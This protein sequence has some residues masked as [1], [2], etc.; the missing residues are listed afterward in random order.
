MK[1]DQPSI[2][3]VDDQVSDL[4]ILG[5]ALD[6]L[7]EVHIATDGKRALELAYQCRPDVIVLDVEMPL[8]DGYSVCEQVKADPRLAHAAVIFVTSHRQ[9]E[10]ELRGL[11]LGGA[12]FLHKP[13][14]PPVA[15]ARVEA[16]IKHGQ[17]VRQ[18]AYYDPLTRLPNRT[19][20]LNRVEQALKNGR[21]PETL[22]GLL[23]IDLDN[24]KALNDSEGHA[25]GDALLQEIARRLAQC[26]SASDTA[27]RAGGQRF[28]LLTLGLDTEALGHRAERVLAAIAQPIV[29]AGV[30]YDLVGHIGISVY[31]QDGEDVETLHQHADAALYQA[32]QS[33]RGHYR[34]F[35]ASINASVRARHQMERDLRSALDEGQL[36]VFYQAKVHVGLRQV[37]GVEALVR[38]PQPDGSM[39]PPDRFIPLAEACGLIVPLGEFVLFSACDALRQWHEEGHDISVSVNISPLQFHDPGFGAMI[40]QAVARSG[41]VPG[42]LELEI[43][44][45]VLASDVD[46]TCRLLGDIRALGVGISIDDFGTGYS[47][48]AYLKRYPLDVLKIDQSFV[49]EMLLQERDTAIVETI[50]RLGHALQ[51]QLVAEG[52]ETTEQSAALQRLGCEIM[53]GYLYCRPMPRARM[54]EYL[55]A[56]PRLLQGL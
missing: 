56:A 11:T 40:R 26:C 41:G 37:V 1:L 50:I 33:G 13:I 20:L 38:W 30:R 8:M 5:Q 42:G 45:G 3:I 44:E 19:L 22:V 27:S 55:R 36:R 29:I 2:L 49:R 28:V 35:N 16:H 51:L 10:H 7:G 54:S 48:L 46:S 18:L 34:F 53:Q 52:V 21:A 25:V 15:R 47:S 6:G 9:T 12:D 4:R 43:T 17:A 23:S 31:P 32:R 39:I 14:N 24:F